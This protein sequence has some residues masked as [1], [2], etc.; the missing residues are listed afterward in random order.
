M[1]AL[2]AATEGRTDVFPRGIRLAPGYG[3]PMI[4]REF[5][6]EKAQGLKPRILLDLY[7]PT[8]VVP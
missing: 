7:G 6:S 5:L 2:A 4:R 3:F 8:K 1:R